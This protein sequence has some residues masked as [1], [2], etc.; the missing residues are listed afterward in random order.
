MKKAEVL[1]ALAQVKDSQDLFVKCN[2]AS[3]CVLLPTRRSC[4]GKQHTEADELWF[5]YRGAAKVC[6]APFSLQLG[7]TAPA[8]PTA[9]EKGTS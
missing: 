3:H 9:W 1:A 4:P 6:L 8:R 5:V 2:A 7:I